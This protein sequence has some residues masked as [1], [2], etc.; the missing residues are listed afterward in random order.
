ME[1]VHAKKN[2]VM[3]NHVRR[4]IAVGC[5]SGSTFLRRMGNYKSFD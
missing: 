3:K 4:G 2:H 5:S 1:D